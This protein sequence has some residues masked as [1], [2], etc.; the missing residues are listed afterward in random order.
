MSQE[1][2]ELVR[3]C[4]AAR[5]RG[6]YRAASALFHPDVVVDLSARPDGRV[7]WGGRDAARAM[8]HWVDLWDDYSYEAEDVLDAGDSVVVLF[9][10]RGRAKASGASVELLGATVWT[11]RDGKVASSK[12]YTDRAEALAAV[13]LAE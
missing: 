9:R 1:N 7:Y 8:Q 4:L 2:V 6:D 5:D 12:T 3:R 11:I 10:E 13:G